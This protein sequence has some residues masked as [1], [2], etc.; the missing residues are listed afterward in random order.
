MQGVTQQRKR[1]CWVTTTPFIV[2]SFLRPHLAALARRHEVTLALNPYDGYPLPAIDGLARIA[3][4]PIRRKIA[5]L[6]DV[7]ALLV[8]IREM[9]LGGYDAVHTF[10]PKAGLLGMLAAWIT[11]V[12]VRMHT[13]QGEVWAS[14][15]GA[16]RALLKLADILTATL[17][18]HVLVV[19]AGER[20]FLEGEH[21]LAP[22][23]GTVL[24]DGSI[25]GVDIARFRPDPQAGARV[26]DKLGVR[27]GQV[28]VLYLGR[29]ARD[30][31]VLDLATAF[32]LA[33]PKIP[34]A[35][36]AFV[37]PD[38]EGLSGEI[39]ACAGKLADRVRLGGYSGQPEEYLAA[40]SF[41]C[42]PSYREGFS[43]VILEAA[44][45]G[46]P[47][48]ASRIYGTQ[49]ALVDGVTGRFHAPGNVEQLAELICELGMNATRCAEMGR[50]ARDRVLERFQADRLVSEMLSFYER[51]LRA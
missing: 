50:A 12:P 18:T 42:L 31:G 38:E 36:L 41:V 48:V 21:V 33:G 49:G 24:G 14:R 10:A 3:A 6:R 4:V 1:L 28:L 45:C 29:L 15:Q 13:F 47:T 25:A 37:G 2:S 22:G 23:R 19:G 5:P 34:D 40:A 17:A 46:L 30:K 32:S 27:E 39:R 9:F 26:R 35:V 44:A 43:T 51:T 20:S 16:M 8:L 11:R 7:V